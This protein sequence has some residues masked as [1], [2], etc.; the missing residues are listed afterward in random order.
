MSA[1]VPRVSVV[2]G[3]HNPGTQALVAAVESVLAH[4][5]NDLEL[6][7]VDDGSDDGVTP[8]TLRRCAAGDARMRVLTVPRGGL[9][10]ALIAGCEAAR[11]PVV[12]RIDAGDRYLPGKLARQLEALERDPQTVLVSCGVR[13]VY[14]DGTVLREEVVHETPE[15]S[16]GHLRT[17]DV[18][19]IRGICHHGTAMFRRADYERA[20]GYR[21]EFR[22]TQD[23]DLWLRLTDRGR[24]AILPE[25]LYEAALAPGSL[26]GL[27]A[28]T[29]QRLGALATAMRV[30]RAAGEPETALLRTAAQLGPLCPGAGWAA[31]RSTAGGEYLLGNLL[32]H[33]RHPVCIRHLQAAVAAHPFH[34]RAWA[35]LLLAMTRRLGR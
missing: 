30:A 23:I 11:A 12:A 31:R 29:Q 19:H 7:V 9:T 26:S 33:K 17:D 14:E 6:I 15:V 5:V 18:R 34:A 16:T 4:D 25:V 27:N 21:R 32:Y 24:V 2:M 8:E 20:G 1:P 13:Y 10:P 35:L 28:A 3:V 22:L